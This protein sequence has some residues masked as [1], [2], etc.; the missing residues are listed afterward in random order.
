MEKARVSISADDTDNPLTE[1]L[2]I[3]QKIE[4]LKVPLFRSLIRDTLEAGQWPV[5][6]VNFR[7]TLEALSEK[8]FGEY[9]IHGGQTET[10]RATS[11]ENFQASS[12]PSL[13]LATIAAGGVGVNLHDMHGDR[14]R[15]S[16]IAPTFNAVHFKQA[17]GRIHRS[18]MKSH[19][20]QK[21]IFAGGTVE[22]GICL[23]VRRK[24]KNIST[25]N[26]EDLEL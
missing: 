20:T 11:I 13:M 21:I 2:R 16:L 23:A 25:L 19:A 26:N 8:A 15:V 18:G 1:S 5:V 12:E 22:E 3:R 10:E 4:L 6:F 9:H 24:L 7:D 14:P 17:L